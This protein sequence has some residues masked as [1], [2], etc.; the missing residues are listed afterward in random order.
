MRHLSARVWCFLFHRRAAWLGGA[1]VA[2]WASTISSYI[3]IDRQTIYVDQREGLDKILF[4]DRSS[5]RLHLL[6]S[7]FSGVPATGDDITRGSFWI[8]ASVYFYRKFPSHPHF[9]GKRLPNHFTCFPS[10]SLMMIPHK[11]GHSSS[12]RVYESVFAAFQFLTNIREGSERRQIR[13][14]S[15]NTSKRV[16]MQKIK[17][18]SIFFF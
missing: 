13:I 16:P 1:R 14:H 10:G 5:F 9:T 15:M 7:W 18:V 17:E 11:L 12:G 3:L 8:I 6:R 2:T 4:I